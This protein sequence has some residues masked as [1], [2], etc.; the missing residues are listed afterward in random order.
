MDL[1][2]SLE[3]VIEWFIA[4]IV[5]KLSTKSAVWLVKMMPRA[6]H[7]LSARIGSLEMQLRW[8]KRTLIPYIITAPF[9]LTW[10]V[11]VVYPFNSWERAF[12]ALAILVL[13]MMSFQLQVLVSSK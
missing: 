13:L 8:P 11:L 5:V 6:Y 10:T 9:Y 1:S 7:F 4:S 2:F 12:A 3:K